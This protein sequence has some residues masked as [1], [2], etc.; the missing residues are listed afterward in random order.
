MSKFYCQLDYEHVPYTSPVSPHGNLSNNGCG[1]CS[2]SMVA[3]NMLGVDFPPEESGKF[4]KA[5]GSREGFGTNLYIY[6]RAF[7][8]HFDLDLTETEDAEEALRFLQQKKGMVIANTQGDRP[9]DGYVGVFSNSGHYIVLAEAE[10]RTVKVWDPM[11]K[12]GS[13]RFE[14]PERKDKVRLDGTD[15]YADISVIAQDCKD[16]PFFLFAKKKAPLI[17]VTCS[18]ETDAIGRDR[19]YLYRNYMQA[20]LDAGGVPLVISVDTPREM[21]E[22]L[23]GRLD[24]LLVT[25][26]EDLLPESYGEENRFS[27]TPCP[28]RDRVEIDAICICRKLGK[29]VLGICR[30]VQ[31]MAAAMGGTLWQDLPKECGTEDRVHYPCHKN[32]SVAQ[33]HEIHVL[34]GSKLAQIA[35][36]GRYSVNSYHHQAVR[37]VP[38]G[39]V[40]SAQSPDGVIEAIESAEGPMFLGVQWHPERLYKED[41]HA[42]ALFRAL[43]EAAR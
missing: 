42:A 6:S 38:E 23:L 16:R 1:P 30:G 28:E 40:A 18:Y 35:G 34:P 20:V 13:D 9:A 31:S 3:E 7:A 36:E 14:I 39:M 15:A 11:Y 32:W 24:G 33:A 27:G 29:P 10:G 43:V 22:P 41:E 37:K 26:G 4:A 8:R 21:L 5:C 12:L 19:F 17:G 25:G 2:G